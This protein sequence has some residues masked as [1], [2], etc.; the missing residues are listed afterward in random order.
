M[1]LSRFNVWTPYDQGLILFNTFTGALATF[2]LIHAKT[3]LKAFEKH[4]VGHIPNE[5]L[6]D[7]IE[8]GYLVEDNQD[9][10][11]SIVDVCAEKQ[12]IYLLLY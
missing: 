7:M 8:D 1:K 4:E 3:L 12:F 5:F 9:E 6:N 11:R 10:F 2:D